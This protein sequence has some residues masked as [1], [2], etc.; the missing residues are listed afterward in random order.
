MKGLYQAQ[1]YN[2][3]HFYWPIKDIRAVKR[4]NLPPLMVRKLMAGLGIPWPPDSTDHTL[5]ALAATLE[6]IHSILDNS[7]T[8]HLTFEPEP[9]DGRTDEI[10]LT[11]DYITAVGKAAWTDKIKDKFVDEGGGVAVDEVIQGCIDVVQSL[12][13]DLKSLWLYEVDRCNLRTDLETY[14]A[15]REQVRL[16][17][18]RAVE[19][20][21]E[22]IG[23]RRRCKW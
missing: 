5:A 16:L 6:N 1:P 21:V 22:M 14:L 11:A 23:E 10:R 12:G 8:Y 9:P 13:D 7:A 18:K 17:S 2:G 4:G 3:C 15:K 19:V 20:T